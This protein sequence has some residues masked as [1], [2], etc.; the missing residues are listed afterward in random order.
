MKLILTS[1]KKTFGPSAK[2]RTKLKSIAVLSYPDVYRENTLANCLLGHEIG[3][4]AVEQSKIVSRVMVGLQFDTQ[5]L[6]VLVDEQRGQ[7]VGPQQTLLTQF[8]S[9]DD[10]RSQIT[11][12]ATSVLNNW[13]QE[14]ASDVFAL[15]ILGPVFIFS[16][17][18]LLL[19]MEN[20]E[21]WSDDHPSA[22][23]R[24]QLLL[25]QNATLGFTPA[26]RKV[27]GKNAKLAKEIVAYFDEMG[28]MLNQSSTTNDNMSKLLDDAFK[29]IKAAMM[30]EVDLMIAR[31]NFS[32]YSSDK[33]VEDIFTMHEAL[34][35]FVPPC[36]DL[37]GAP[38]NVVSI[39][40]AGMAFMISGKE[41]YYDYLEAKE[42]KDELRAEAK[43]QELILK[44]IELSYF[45][46]MMKS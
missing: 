23:S 3:H 29:G 30:S 38:G 11:D 4:F 28:I 12:T 6:Q 10:M 14:F 46:R 5:I 15:E 17:E 21:D 24:L 8:L 39:L 7:R 26:L 9:D 13:V 41:L 18:K 27:E 1:T 43:I 42:L 35:C 31:Q 22:K 36:D 33:M 20:P 45:E 19:T 2:V 40:N 44:G 34:A 25:E 32:R 37:S 16:L